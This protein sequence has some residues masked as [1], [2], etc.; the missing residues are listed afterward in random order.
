M[1]TLEDKAFYLERVK[2]AHAAL[3]SIKA[4]VSELEVAILSRSA[5]LA[6]G[7]LSDSEIAKLE[8][9]VE[10]ADLSFMVEH[11]ASERF[12]VASVD[13]LDVVKAYPCAPNY[14]QDIAAARRVEQIAA[15]EFERTAE[16]C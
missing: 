3:E 4:G 13:Y 6:Q 7:T 5:E 12:H 1:Y 8:A 2:E 10:F 15:F 16:F 14:D 9:D 11:M